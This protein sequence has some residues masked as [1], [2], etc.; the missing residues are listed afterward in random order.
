MTGAKP[1]IQSKKKKKKAIS[2]T[3][4]TDVA[5]SPRPAPTPKSTPAVPISKKALKRAKAKEKKAADDE[6]DQALAELSLKCVPKFMLQRD[7]LIQH[8]YQNSH[9]LRQTTVTGQTFADLLSVSV[10]Y[11]DSDAEM[12]KFFG[13]KVVQA[14][15]EASSSA[16]PSRRK[17]PAI[18]SQLTQPKPTWW[19]AKGREGLSIRVLAENELNGKLKRHGWQPMPQEKWWTVEYSKR[20]KSLTKVFMGTVYSGGACASSFAK[21]MSNRTSRSSGLLGLIG[22]VAVAGRHSLAGVGSVSSP[23]R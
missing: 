18:R 3:P 5:D 2:E 13:S 6:L 7:V 20:Y 12:R 4:K 9:D 23:G 22:K 14:N 17:A 19:A 21:W 16:G 8:R 11:L 10:H 1:G 15:K